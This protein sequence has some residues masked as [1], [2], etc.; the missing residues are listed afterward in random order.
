MKRSPLHSEEYESIPSSLSIMALRYLFDPRPTQARVSSSSA[1]PHFTPT[2]STTQEK[3]LLSQV[4]PSSATSIPVEVPVPEMSAVWLAR[5]CL[6]VF[7]LG[8]LLVVLIYQWIPHVSSLVVDPVVRKD[9]T[10]MTPNIGL[11]TWLSSSFGQYSPWLPA[12][13]YPP[14]PRGCHLDQINIV[15][16]RVARKFFQI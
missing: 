15:S 6:R 14:V 9:Y 12:G 16:A 5:W 3:V 4:I 1:L 7:T 11:P 2:S 10:P 8:T 13:P